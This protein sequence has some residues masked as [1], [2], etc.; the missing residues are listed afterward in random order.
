[1][2]KASERRRA[3]SDR[4]SKPRADSTNRRKSRKQFFRGAVLTIRL[5]IYKT[6]LLIVLA[7]SYLVISLQFSERA[8]IA[9][10]IEKE[11]AERSSPSSKNYRAKK[12]SRENRRKVKIRLE[13][14]RTPSSQKLESSSLGDVDL[15]DEFSVFLKSNSTQA[16]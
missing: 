10:G 9:C 1:M 5:P 2:K 14:A 13:E 15:S 4:R 6:G 16:N 11:V 8:H 3:K 12:I 7:F